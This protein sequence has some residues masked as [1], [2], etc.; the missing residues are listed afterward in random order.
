M[1]LKKIISIVF[2]LMIFAMPLSARA[3]ISY[4]DSQGN[5]LYA[6]CEGTLN[7]NIEESC[8]T[9]VSAVYL[10]GRLLGIDMSE[11]QDGN[12]SNTLDIPS[13]DCLVKTFVFDNL[14]D[15]KPLAEAEELLKSSYKLVEYDNTPKA[16]ESSF[17]SVKIGEEEIFTEDYKD[18]SYARF[19]LGAAADI[20]ISCAEEIESFDISPH[21]LGIEAQAAGNRLNFRVESGQKLIVTVN[22][23]R[24]LFIF[25]DEPEEDAPKP[26]DEGVYLLTD[27]PGIDSS[28]TNVITAAFQAA[29]DDVADKSG[30]LFV[31]N[32]VYLTGH[33]KIHSGVSLYLESGALIQGT[34]D[35][36]DYPNPITTLDGNQMLISALLCFDTAEDARLFGRG[37][38]DGDGLNLRAQGRD[39]WLI[40]M[41]QCNNVSVSDVV[42]RD[43]AAFNTH[44][45]YSDNI[46]I[47]GVK[48]INDITNPNTDGID[49]DSSVNV[50]IQN[51]FLYCSDDTVSVKT[52]RYSTLVRNSY[53][54]VVRNNVFWTKK[55]AMKIGDETSSHRIHDVLFENN[56]IIH[57]DRAMTIYVYDGA[58]VSNIRF[59]NNRSEFIG[60][61]NF[62]R[63]MDFWVRTRGESCYTPGK[64][65]N[66]VVKDYYAESFSEQDSSIEGYS[67]EHGVENVYIDNFCV[68]GVKMESLSEAGIDIKDHVS[69]VI[70]A[71]APELPEISEDIPA[72]GHDGIFVQDGD[73]IAVEAEHYVKN[74]SGAGG[75]W[76]EVSETEKRGAIGGSAMYADVSGTINGG[77]FT[78][79]PRLDYKVE[80]KEAGTYYLWTRTYGSLGAGNILHAGVDNIMKP[81]LNSLAVSADSGGWYWNNMNRSRGYAVIE[82]T[83]P[84]VHTINI[85]AGSGGLYFDRFILLKAESG[86]E[87]IGYMSTG[88]KGMGYPE[89]SYRPGTVG[90]TYNGVSALRVYDLYDGM[91]SVQGNDNWYYKYSPIGVYELSEYTEYPFYKDRA[92]LIAAGDFSYGRIRMNGGDTDFSAGSLADAS[93]VFKAPEAGILEISVRDNIIEEISSTDISRLRIY[94]NNDQIFP[95]KDGEW[96]CLEK[97]DKYNFLPLYTEAV[98]G[99]EIIFRVN[100]GSESE[101]NIAGA[102][103]DGDKMDMIP[104]IKYVEF[105]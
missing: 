2:W 60:G 42:L 27:Y 58:T 29:L 101:T 28:G 47:D 96:L 35:R 11:I 45:Q 63:H 21:S 104:V 62:E 39:A 32:G 79:S 15:M 74:E 57:A 24:K 16:V 25:A 19:S 55:S 31:P 88:K 52:H 67:E 44:I 43:P 100:K 90:D 3:E 82:I 46:L 53:D 4:T 69:Q 89:S 92:W 40:S 87:N 48:I 56:D 1:Q 81:S 49:P 83:E 26:G 59:I 9:A 77:E 50:T 22:D 72:Y 71:A 73:Y 20:E 99:D 37:T 51:N 17:Y 94:K 91:S 10:D 85:W 23:G 38:I 36:S 68:G 97:G 75:S 65:E 64:I 41:T 14:S 34:S 13:E 18:I 102:K 103:N 105:D 7:I 78:K 61:D 33:L 76:T 86:E 95:E 66:I 12:V 54:I 98:Q 70:F 80:F 5:P 30:I 84:G 93:L 6:L 8:G